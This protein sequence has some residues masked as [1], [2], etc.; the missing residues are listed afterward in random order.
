MHFGESI[1]EVINEDFGDGIMSTIDFYC[2]V[3]KLKGID[4][5]DRVVI[6]LDGKI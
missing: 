4:G 3:D 2:S 1:K 5:K 6:I